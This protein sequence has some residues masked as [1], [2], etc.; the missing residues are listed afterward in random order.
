MASH[1]WTE[2]ERVTTRL[3]ELR[4]LLD[5]AEDANQIAAIYALE[6]EITVVETTRDRLLH[7][8]IERVADEAAV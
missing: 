2:L 8:L 7:G 5:A 4:N 6:E 3:D 1:H